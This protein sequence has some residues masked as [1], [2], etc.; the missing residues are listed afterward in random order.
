MRQEVIEM[1]KETI[2]NKKKAMELLFIFII[3]L[4]T[5]IVSANGGNQIDSLIEK[6][7]RDSNLPGMAVGIIKNGES[8]YSDAKGIDGYEEDL[9]ETTP[10]FIGSISKSF[11]ALAVMQ[12]VEKDLINLDAPIREYIPYFKV[13]NPKLSESITVRQV[14]IQQTGLSRKKQ[15]PSSNYNIT[16]KERVQSLSNMEEIVENGKEFH[17]LNDHY[18]I[19]GL[20]IEEVTGNSYASYMEKNVFSPMKLINTT[21]DQS[22]IEEKNIYGY[23]NIFGFTKRLNE[24]V[25]HYEIP[26]GYILSNLQDMNKYISFLIEPDE[27]ILSKES[28]DEMRTI[29]ANSDYAMGWHIN[30]VN[31]LKIIAHSGLVNTFSAHIAFIPEIKSGYFYI[32]NKGHIIHQFDKTYVTLNNNLLQVILG[33]DNFEYFPSIW[34]IRFVSLIFLMLTAKDIWKTRNLINAAK[35]KK[36][37]IKE[38]VKALVVLSFLCLGL[39]Y[40]LRNVL[41]LGIDLRY[42]LGYAPD[43]TILLFVAIVLQVITLTIVMGNIIRKKYN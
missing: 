8:I 12:L 18:A 30:E 14:L 36:E 39:P 37:W 26:S 4:T 21:A 11:T 34:V 35:S 3:V 43:F 17:Y 7:M 1:K 6:S 2:A 24:K 5:T 28:I 42:M 19:L 32:I 9:T 23:T 16:L 31:E 22:A 38:G 13:A 15:L 29:G 41:G 40:I 27:A 10:M 25:P 20:L 33:K